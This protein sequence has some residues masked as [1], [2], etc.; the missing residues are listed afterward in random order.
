VYNPPNVSPYRS[1]CSPQFRASLEVN[2]LPVGKLCGVER[3]FAQMKC[4]VPWEALQYSSSLVHGCL[5]CLEPESP[6]SRRVPDVPSVVQL[7]FSL[8][9]HVAKLV[10]YNSRMRPDIP[11][12]LS[13]YR[14]VC[15][16]QFCISLEVNVYLLG[17]CE[18][19]K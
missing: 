2:L 3:F 11:P 4:S 14:S 6:Q 18:L 13:P 7:P 16:P 12:R 10:V 9:G 19:D 17:L 15:S 5:R 8:S 1:V